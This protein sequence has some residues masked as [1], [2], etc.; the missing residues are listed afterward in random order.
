MAYQGSQA[1]VEWIP[2]DIDV[3][4]QPLY[5]QQSH[6]KMTHTLPDGTYC[7]V[8][9]S[10]TAIIFIHGLGLDRTVWEN[11]VEALSPSLKTVVYDL[12]GHGKTARTD[13]E[14][15]VNLYAAQLMRLMDE[16]TIDRAV[17]VGFSLGGLIARGFALKHPERVSGVALM[18]TWFQRTPEEERRVAER[19]EVAAKLG[20]EA[21]VAPALVRWFSD[22]Y[23][24]RSP[25]TLK[26]IEIMLKANDHAS[27]ISAYRVAV[28]PGT[29]SVDAIEKIK[30]P[31][32]VM[33]CTGDR[34]NS[35]G[36]AMRM[37]ENI[38][39][40]ELVIL[41]GLRHMALI[42]QPA[43]VNAPLARLATRA[44][45]AAPAY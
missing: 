20:P 8:Q 16:L 39:G 15:S 35:P 34:G 12:I 10:G 5:D 2:G 33:T 4:R 21:S 18:N 44:E 23:R 24:E 36:M 43:L 30:V 25:E 38:E 13:A 6:P 22:A 14:H 3:Q 7:E 17:I 26:K 11:Q 45:A 41:P 40:S 37:S 1:T 31:A 19:M 32:L 28:E 9:G 42:E 27:Y 29:S